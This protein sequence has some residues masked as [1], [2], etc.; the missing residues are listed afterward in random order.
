MRIEHQ[1]IHCTSCLNYENCKHLENKLSDALNEHDGNWRSLIHD[2]RR[3][4]TPI[5]RCSQAI[6]KK[7]LCKFKDS[8]VL[9]IG[10]G[11]LSEIDVNFC[12]ENNIV[13]VGIDPERLPTPISMPWFKLLNGM[14]YVL[15]NH[16]IK[17]KSHYKKNNFQSY[18]KGTVF[19]EHLSNESFDLI[20]ANNSIEH[21]HEEVQ[22]ID[23]SLELYR[24]DISRCYSLLRPGGHLLVNLPIHVHGNKIFMHGE[25][26]II[27]RFFDGN[28]WGSVV[29]EHWRE[30]HDDLM[31][32]APVQRKKAWL[33]SFGFELT[34]IWLGNIV[35]KKRN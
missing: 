8:H 29:F 2:G 3:V 25:V 33:S 12:R 17:Y 6:V 16:F 19:S 1:N 27:E 10:C 30:Q 32:Y 5:R 28:D 9:E 4:D 18:I 31:P 21:W 34:N 13:Y 24:R 15:F 7:H 22:D 26:D 20:Y 23:Q 11:P 14:I 35:A